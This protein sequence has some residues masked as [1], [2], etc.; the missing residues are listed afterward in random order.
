MTVE[1]IDCPFCGKSS[2]YIRHHGLAAV[3]TN[4]R[5]TV[6]C[7]ICGPFVTSKVFCLNRPGEAR[8]KGLTHLVSGHIRERSEYDGE[9]PTLDSYDACEAI[10]KGAPKS[11]L[12]RARKLLRVFCRKST[13]FGKVLE[14][15][16]EKDYPLAYAQQ[17]QEFMALTNLLHSRG[18][19][20]PTGTW[21]S[22]GSIAFVVTAEGFTELESVKSL[23]SHR[24]FV[25]MSFANEMIPA[26]LDAIS[27]A[28]LEC[29]YDP[30]RVDN[31]HFNDDVV[32]KIMAG[33]RESRFVV[34]E[35]SLHRNGVYFEAGFGMGLG[36]PI[37]FACR[38]DHATATHFDV[39][40]FNCIR[41]TTHDELCGKLKDRII[42]TIGRGPLA[43]PPIGSPT[44]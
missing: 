28:I 25:A 19:I 43:P 2:E 34:A 11:I 38:A 17:P 5:V 33:V 13:H 39:E 26:F 8:L 18:F 14:V 6:E 20:K 40:H 29:G 22:F 23:D 35:L 27:P 1:Q 16:A 10:L 31:E 21:D 42:G 36:I 4:A 7:K 41:W 15:H 30:M 9:L 37:I 12:D 24:G 32:A 44:V 3:N